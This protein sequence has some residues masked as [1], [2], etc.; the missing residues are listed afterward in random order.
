MSSRRRWRAVW[1]QL[2]LWGGLLLGGVFALLGLTG[3]ILCFYPEID[4][5]LNPAQQVAAPATAPLP[6][7]Q[8]ILDAL[9]ADRPAYTAAWRLEMPLAPGR[10]LNVRYYRPPETASRDFA[11]YMATVDPGRQVISSRRYWGDYAM[12]WIYDLHYTLL[13]GQ[14]GRTAV[15]V[16]GLLA[17]ASLITGLYLWWPRPGRWA[18]ALRPQIRRGEVRA[19]YDWHVRAGAYG[20]LVLL[21]LCFSGALLALPGWFNPLINS[22]S[23]LTR[24]ES[25]SS[26]PSPGQPMIS[27]D[28]AAERALSRHPGATLRW[29][30]TPAD[31]HGTYRINLWQAGDPGYRFPRSNAWIDAYTGAVLAERDWQKN[32]AGD[33]FLAWQHPL[34]NGE[35]FGLPGRI[36]ASLAGLLPALLWVTGVLR[37]LHKR[38]ARRA[39]R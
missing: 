4:L 30:E 34:H 31:H 16:V 20:A 8:P 38:R 7:L 29:I 33:S 18:A 35:A 21:V 24:S 5:W 22:L 2:H 36:V 12:T 3:S 32:S 13:L 26:A 6:A 39:P 17:L 27:A 25:V 15:G 37:W 19:T 23:P 11:P 14:A 10:P 28:L 9:R 1:L